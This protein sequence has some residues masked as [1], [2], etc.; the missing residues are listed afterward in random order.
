MKFEKVFLRAALLMCALVFTLCPFSLVSYASA[1]PTVAS[2]PPSSGP[3]VGGTVDPVVTFKDAILEKDIR[4]V[5][6]KLQGDIYQSDLVHLTILNFINTGTNKGIADLTGLEYCTSLQALY[7]DNNQITNI[8]PLSGLINLSNLNLSGNQITDISPLSGLAKLSNLNLYGNQITNIS[9]LSELTKLDWLNLSNNQITNISSLS[10]LTHLSNLNLSDNQITNISALVSNNSLSGGSFISLIGNHLDISAGSATMAKIQALIDRGVTIFYDPQFADP[11]I[12]FP[13]ANLESMVL[14]TALHKRQGDIH[15]SDVVTLRYLDASGRGITDLTGLEYCINLT[16]LYLSDNQIKDISPFRGL[17]NL[18]WLILSNNQITDISPLG[19]LT[20]LDWLDLSNNQITNIAPLSGLTMLCGFLLA[21]NQITDI[22][23]LVS[24]NSLSADSNINLIGNQLDISAGSATMA[25]IQTLIDRGVTIYYDPQFVD[26]IIT[27]NDAGLASAIRDALMEEHYLE[28]DIHQSALA[29]L[30]YLDASDRGI[31][32]LTGLEYCTHLSAL[33]LNN[34]LIT[35]ITPLSS[36]T[37]LRVLNL[38]NL[39]PDWIT[40]DNN[41]I[42]DIS[43]LSG[44][45]NLDWLILDNNQITDISPLGGLTNLCNL[46]LSDNQITDISPLSGLTNL[47][48][49]LNLSNNQIT[50]ISPLGGLTK[51]NEL[52]LSNNRITDISPLGYLSKL[53]RLY[54]DKNQVTDI[55]SL[56]SNYGL[57]AVSYYVNLSLNPLDISAGSATM[58]N[59]QTLIDRGVTIYYDPQGVDPIVIFKDAKLEAAVRYSLGGKQGDI[60]QSDMANVWGLYCEGQGITDLTGLEYCTN[61]YQLHLEQNQITDIS[62]LSGCTN[63]SEVYLSN[64]RI[65]DLS[66]LSGCYN[67]YLASLELHLEQ[68]QITDLSPLSG[69]IDLSSLYLSDNRITDISPLGLTQVFG[70]YL[71]RNQITDISAL[72]GLTELGRVY[73]SD[74]QITDISP[75]VTNAVN[76]YMILAGIGI[77]INLVNNYLDTAP[78]SRAMNDIQFLIDIGTRTKYV[79]VTYLPQRATATT[80]AANSITIN[81]ATLN[82]S[83]NDNGVAITS[84]TFDYGLTTAY[85]STLIVPPLGGISAGTGAIPVNG[86]ISG[87]TPGTIYHFRVNAVYAGGTTNGSDMTFTTYAYT[88][89]YTPGAHGSITGTSSQMVISGGAGTTVTA[90][91]AANYHFVNWSDGVATAARTDT[92]VTANI[93]VTANFAINTYTLTYT[94]GSHGSISGISPQAVNYGASGTSV[95]A[96]PATGYH[97]VNWSDAVTTAARS[98]TNMTANLSVTANFAINTYTLTYS[99]GANGSI[100]GTTPQTVNYGVAGTTVTAVPSNGCY[101]VNWSDG[102]GTAARTDT[103]VT[104]NISVTANFAINTYILTYTAGAN[105]TITGP[106]PQTVYYGASGTTVTAVPAANYHFVNWSDGLGTAARTDTNVT[107]NISVTANFAINTYILTYTAGAH[108]TI[109]GTSPQTVNYGTAG[110]NVTAVPDTGYHFVSWSD[111][112]TAAARTDTNVIASISVTA[113]FAINTSTTTTTVPVTTTTTIPVTMP[114]PAPVTTPTLAP[115]TTTTTTLATTTITTTTT[116]PGT[117]VSSDSVASIFI[118]SGVIGHDASGAAFSQ[119]TITPV[120]N[121]PTPPSNANG[122]GLY[123]DFEP[124]GATFTD[125]INITIKYDPLALPAGADQSK[126]YIAWWDTTTGEWINLPSVVDQVN[127]TITARV[128]H[129]TTYSAFIPKTPGS[130]NGWVIG[131]ISGGII[132]I[133]LLIWFVIRRKRVIQPTT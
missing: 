42:T 92:N 34:N 120:T 21:N 56:A 58:T 130:K 6:P 76:S 1:A 61:L 29:S 5:V 40:L 110:A 3:A 65:T 79:T 86:A 54:L 17:T 95:T 97:F 24:N 111:N 18:D 113:N 27:F 128:T 22:S 57:S 119:I 115:V 125:P 83:V 94:A 123:Y 69:I 16:T 132:I 117:F 26:P 53:H 66:P 19:G 46:D 43:P 77:D 10:G 8:L 122:I 121:P 112:V 108:G 91:P 84:V 39:K 103:N 99:A 116:T 90:V 23:A 98:D 55:S 52:R 104:T 7:L 72:S 96:I 49:P 93:S 80:A 126:L 129:F 36:C 82:G 74:N 28:A 107:T 4:S 41:Q 68:N 12:I 118:P 75:L 13:D 127:H 64:N 87:L 88:L 105:G 2:I 78:G 106:S 109:T 89:T 48:Y 59:I 11:I 81:G 9:P 67:L 14:W 124:S 73:L 100:S 70:L 31:T 51:L 85:G 60:H 62:P 32:D 45:T 133:G 20:K 50:D 131:G 102:L 37:N 47:W 25:N 35:D 101:F 15:Q 71:E 38:S 63:L 44:L 33:F 30:R 114:T